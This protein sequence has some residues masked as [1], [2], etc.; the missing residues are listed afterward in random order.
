MVKL[1]VNADDFG[2][3]KGVNLGII[4]T[5]TNGILTSTTML[6][7]MY[8][9]E[10][11][12]DLMKEYPKLGIGVHLTLTC[13]KPILENVNSLIDKHGNFKKLKVLKE[14][15]NMNLNQI[16]EE[17]EAQIQ[18]LLN[19]GVKLTHIDSHHYVHS[20]DSCVK[21]VETLAKKYSLP[22][23][24]CFDI[25]KKV[26]E[27]KIFITETFWNLF[28]ILSIKNMDFDYNIVKDNIY[29]IIEGNAKKYS[30]YSIIEASCHPAYVDEELYFGSSFNLARMREIKILCDPELDRILKKYN[31]EYVNYGPF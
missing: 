14:E 5:H 15:N 22:V 1:I 3:S 9:F 17:W 31:F 23:R 10:N 25:D 21:I 8:G 28:N 7:N 27:T 11:G 2:Y 6:A 18:K 20:F 13:G 16:Y 19:N 30:K 26:K 12:I 24:N 29:E 4:E